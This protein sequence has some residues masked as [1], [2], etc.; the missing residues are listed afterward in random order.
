MKVQQKLTRYGVVPVASLAGAAPGPVPR[1]DPPSTTG[2]EEQPAKHKETS[3]TR[4]NGNPTGPQCQTPVSGGNEGITKKKRKSGTLN[5]LQFNASGI[6]TKKF[7][8]A[9]ILNKNNL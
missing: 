8:L 3:K 4:A 5:I 9:H 1:T 7:E 6:G 2:Q